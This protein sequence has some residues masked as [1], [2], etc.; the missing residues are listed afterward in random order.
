MGSTGGLLGWRR[1]IIRVDADELLWIY[2]GLTHT[3]AWCC[4]RSGAGKRKG[5]TKLAM[6]FRESMQAGRTWR[7]LEDTAI[8]SQLLYTAREAGSSWRVRWIITKRANDLAGCGYVG[9]GRRPASKKSLMISAGR[10]HGGESGE[11]K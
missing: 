11:P 2:E 8:S 3:T 7:D 4:A 5:C 1:R 10:F 9:F 6:T